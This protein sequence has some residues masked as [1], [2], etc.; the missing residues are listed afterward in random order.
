MVVVVHTAMQIYREQIFESR[1][2]HS[3][4]FLPC[5]AVMDVIFFN[6]LNSAAYKWMLLTE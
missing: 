3:A 5:N 4:T 2:W 6:R 1:E